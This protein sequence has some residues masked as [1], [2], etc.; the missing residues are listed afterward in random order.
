M[1]EAENFMSLYK[2]VVSTA[3]YNF[4]VNREELIGTTEHLTL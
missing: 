3:E 4:V 2:S 1:K